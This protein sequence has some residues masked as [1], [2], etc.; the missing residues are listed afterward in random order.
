MWCNF[1]CF[2][3]T[4]TECEILH[5]LLSDVQMKQFQDQSE[6]WKKRGAERTNRGNGSQISSCWAASLRNAETP[7]Y[8]LNT[9]ALWVHAKPQSALCFNKESSVKSETQLNSHSASLMASHQKK[10]QWTRLLYFRAS[11]STIRGQ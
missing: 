8:E 11:S 6:W 1:F 3:V 10:R 5:L 7:G 9:S 4:P 2:V